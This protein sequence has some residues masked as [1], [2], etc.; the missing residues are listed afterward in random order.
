MSNSAEVNRGSTPTIHVEASAFADEK[1]IQTRL[2]ARDDGAIDLAMTRSDAVT[3]AAIRASLQRIIE[4]QTIAIRRSPV[5]ARL[6]AV[7]IV[8]RSEAPI[9][10]SECVLSEVPAFLKTFQDCRLLDKKDG[11]VILS[12]LISHEQLAATPYSKL[13][14]LGRGM[15]DSC[16]LG[17]A[18]PLEGL[19]EG[20]FP[21]CMP[22]PHAFIS[23]RYMVGVSFWNESGLEPALWNNPSGDHMATWR[24]RVRG[25]LEFQLLEH[26]AP[27]IRVRVGQPRPIYAAILE[28]L[29]EVIR[30]V[31]GEFVEDICTGAKKPEA[32]LS[33]SAD[34][35]APA[36]CGITVEI[37]TA[38]KDVY[39]TFSHNVRVSDTE[40]LAATFRELEATLVAAGAEIAAKSFS[41][42]QHGHANSRYAH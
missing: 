28:G 32:I 33:I 1:W 27:E 41:S 13:Y 21:D 35:A 9:E 30:S 14:A 40:R 39:W 7:P 20:E 36:G 6:F 5:K 23:V 38:A 3:A 18:T 2:E 22:L 37:S 26:G 24:Q 10:S 17:N 16:V 19:A 29:S 12:N 25:M 4:E 31:L 15:M 34:G 11:V 42:T 8:L